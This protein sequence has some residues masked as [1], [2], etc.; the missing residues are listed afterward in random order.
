MMFHSFIDSFNSI[1]CRDAAAAY[2]VYAVWKAQCYIVTRQ[3]APVFYNALLPGSG[4]S[5]SCVLLPKF[6]Y[7]D[8]AT[9]FSTQI[10]SL[11]FMICVAD[12]RD[13]CPRQSP[14]NLSR[15]LSPTFPVYCNEL[16]SIRASRATQRNLSRTCH[17]LCCKHHYMLR[18][19]VFATFVICVG[20][21]DWNFMISGFVTIWV[22]DFPREE[23][24]VKVSVME[25]ELLV[26]M[27]SSVCCVHLLQ[28]A[29]HSAVLQPS[30]GPTFRNV[31]L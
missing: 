17:G 23:V 12:L 4:S 31:N 27:M 29:G 11:N 6:H 14:Q 18:W 26:L 5:L 8:F 10:T 15:T 13:L 28:W 1:S 24:L 20:D 25:F 16:N 19:F 3:V 22:R 7:A 2:K 30:V 21:F 9:K